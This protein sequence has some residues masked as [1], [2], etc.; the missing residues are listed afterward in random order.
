MKHASR[1]TFTAISLSV[2]SVLVIASP[3]VAQ[4][5]GNGIV[6]PPEEC[7]DG[8]FMRLD[9]CAPDCTFEHVQRM[10]MLAL[11]D[12]TGPATCTPATNVFGSAFSGAG[13]TAVNT[14]L[15]TVIADRTLNQLLQILDLDDPAGADDPVL[16]VGLLGS[17]PDVGGPAPGLDAWY[18]AQPGFLDPDDLPALRLSGATAVRELTA[19]PGRIEISFLGGLIAARDAR[20]SAVVGA[21]TSLPGPPPGQFAPGFS[22]FE[23]LTADDGNHGICANLTVG[24]LALIPLPQEF[25]AGGAAECSSSCAGSRSYTWCGPGNPVGPGCNSMLD[26]MVGGCAVF[27]PLCIGVV[28]PTQPDV[29]TGGQPPVV[30]VGDPVTGKVSVT[31]P[32]DA[33]STWFEFT[34]ERVHMTN[35]I[36]GIFTDGFESADLG[37]WSSSVP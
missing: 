13:L 21:T 9:G 27:P 37:A 2:I 36:G 23:G 12:G 19:G 17:D 1:S 35:N 4:V 29:G 14:Q 22:A 11:A 8:A 7:D 24:S 20:L 33:Y 32:E 34:S 28:A 5:C 26:L 31:E 16:E 18:V 15:A 25:T 10:T 30:L 6:E 3:C